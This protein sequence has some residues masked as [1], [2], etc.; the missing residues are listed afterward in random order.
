MLKNLSNFNHISDYLPIITAALI[1]DM[2]VI[3]R[4]VSG[5]IKI[6]SL[7]QWYNKF[8]L[9][10][11]IADVLSIV[12]GIIVARYL[13]PFFFSEYSLLQFILL[14][15]AVQITHDISFAAIFNSIPR[16][17]SARLDVFKDYAKE[18]G[19]KILL[20]DAIMMIAT[21]LLGSYLATLTTNSIIIILIISLYILPYLLYSIKKRL[22]LYNNL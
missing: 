6:N 14:T 1:V 7:N 19:F 13:Y 5:Y 15:C 20:A 2:F 9:A 11:V 10:A 22:I 21:I 12:I 4:I 3:F 16:N 18:V 8:G 17:S